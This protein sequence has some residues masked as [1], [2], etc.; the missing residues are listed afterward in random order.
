LSKPRT[1]KC[2]EGLVIAISIEKMELKLLRE[3]VKLGEGKRTEFKLKTK[4][5]EKI[6]R[7]LVAF[8]NSEGGKLIV[9][10]RDDRVIIGLK[11][12]EEDLYILTRAIEKW[13]FPD[14]NFEVERILIDSDREVLVFHIPESHTKPH[15]VLGLEGERRVYVRVG[16]QSIQASREVK[17]ILR[18]SKF[19]T[20]TLIQYGPHERILMTLLDEQG[21]ITLSLFASK[22]GI[23]KRKASDILIT[24]VLAQVIQIHPHEVEDTYTLSTQFVARQK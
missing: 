3:L 4:H 13:I 2:S 19:N 5:P 7:E 21:T 20:N 22:A 11:D 16:E 10:V 18:R 15:H 23:A 17:Q 6:V 1:L 14:L 12:S 8:A 24:M 9:G